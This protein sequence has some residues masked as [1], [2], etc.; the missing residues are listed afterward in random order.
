MNYLS[1]LILIISIVI[2]GLYIKEKFSSRNIRTTKCYLWTDRFEDKCN[3]DEVYVGR[4]QGGCALGQGRA[5]CGSRANAVRLNG[6]SR[7]NAIL[8]SGFIRKKSML[9]YDTIGGDFYSTSDTSGL[10]DALRRCNNDPNCGGVSHYEGKKF[11]RFFK[12]NQVLSMG[13]I[14]KKDGSTNPWGYPY[15]SYVKTES[16]QTTTN[17]AFINLTN[18]QCL[19]KNGISLSTGD[20]EDTE[21]QW[22]LDGTSR[23]NKYRLIN[24]TG[25]CIKDDGTGNIIIQPNCDMASDSTL[26]K[27]VGTGSIYK[28][29]KN[30]GTE[31]CLTNENN[32]I[33]SKPCYSV[34]N[35]GKWAQKAMGL[36]GKDFCDSNP[37]LIDPTDQDKID[38]VSRFCRTYLD[39]DTSNE[40]KIKSSKCND[41]CYNFQ[42]YF[43]VGG[44]QWKPQTAVEQNWT[45]P[46]EWTPCLDR[47]TTDFESI[48]KAKLGKGQSSTVSRDN[49]SQDLWGVKHYFDICDRRGKP[50][51]R[52]ECDT[53]WSKGKYFIRPKS[54]N[55]RSWTSVLDK[56]GA[57]K[58]NALYGS[59]ADYH[60]NDTNRTVSG[61]GA[62]K[63][64]K[65]AEPENNVHGCTIPESGPTNKG[66]SEEESKTGKNLANTRIPIKKY[67]SG[68]YVSNCGWGQGRTQCRPIIRSKTGKD[69]SIVSET[70]YCY[71]NN[72]PKRTLDQVC[73]NA[74]GGGGSIDPSPGR[75]VQNIWGVVSKFRGGCND[76]KSKLLCATGYSNGTRL[77]DNSTKC[78]SGRERRNAG[79]RGDRKNTA[80][81]KQVGWGY[82]YNS[83]GG[84]DFGNSLN[85]W[86][87]K[88]IEY[89]GGCSSG[90][91]R[92][93]CKLDQTPMGTIRHTGCH[94]WGWIGNWH[95]QRKVCQQMGP[96][97]QRWGRDGDGG[98]WGTTSGGEGSAR[99]APGEGHC[100]WGKDR[101]QC[102][103]APSSA[104]WLINE[105]P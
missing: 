77:H 80:C 36:S 21:S 13:P 33:S 71:N 84:K 3:D 57:D 54:T 35:N 68:R 19:R 53:K 88:G 12:K 29:L 83:R 95:A 104:G 62:P 38:S 52:A 49:P 97:Y 1:I 23:E 6:S 37:R 82:Y 41:F 11:F 85:Q 79:D 61:C 34:D 86:Y 100:A 66:M 31:K 48:C 27:K 39:S 74:F 4:T 101:S 15:V 93:T 10:A 67:E 78:M 25:G 58:C 96:H 26:W 92:I 44:Q 24:K 20:C 9:S 87:G 43:G 50:R 103:R 98:Q 75:P 105:M 17:K 73:Q 59:N 99:F 46:P 81:N 60:V 18:K 91:K 2:S 22:V 70:T 14:P 30:I 55:C 102:V 16:D 45:V 94:D 63:G 89:D 7:A 47:D 90:Q 28:R 32:V 65:V 8:L 40:N 64:V 5:K 72:L 56:S 42:S 76:N 69:G 51:V